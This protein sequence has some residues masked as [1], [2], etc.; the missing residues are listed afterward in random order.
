MNKLEMFL[1]LNGEPTRKTPPKSADFAHNY[2]LSTRTDAVYSDPSIL[3]FREERKRIIT[4][5]FTGVHYSKLK[6]MDFETV[7]IQFAL[8]HGI[9]PSRMVSLSCRYLPVF[10]ELAGTLPD[11]HD[12]LHAGCGRHNLIAVTLIDQTGARD[13]IEIRLQQAYVEQRAASPTAR[14]IRARLQTLFDETPKQ[15]PL[16]IEATAPSIRKRMAA[17]LSRNQ[18]ASAQLRKHGFQCILE[19]GEHEL[20]LIR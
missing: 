4:V 16:R 6:T 3:K 1:T 13:E 14:E 11:P 15:S 2:S 18:R 12:R 20:L 19:S 8:Y 17:I 9:G 10:Q 5:L 7:D